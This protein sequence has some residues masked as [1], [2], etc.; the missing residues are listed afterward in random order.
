MHLGFNL[1]IALSLSIWTLAL[2]QQESDFSNGQKELE[3]LGSESRKDTNTNTIHN[4]RGGI[5]Q[6]WTGKRFQMKCHS[7]NHHSIHRQHQWHFLPC[8]PGY[9]RQSCKIL[10]SSLTTDTEWQVVQSQSLLDELVLESPMEKDN[11]LYKCS[12]IRHDGTLKV[13]RMFQLEVNDGTVHVPKIVEGPWNVSVVYYGRQQKI[14]LQCRVTSSV[15][16]KI[17]WFRR[18]DII[19][20]T[21]REDLII[22]KNAGWKMLPSNQIYLDDQLY[23]SKLS[24]DQLNLDDSGYYACLAINYKGW[25]MQEAHLKVYLPLNSTPLIAIGRNDQW[26]G[27]KFFSLFLIP[28][29]LALV[30]ASAWLCYL[31]HKPRNKQNV[32]FVS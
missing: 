3:A 2:I 23:L 16:P 4:A 30:P 8:G 21:G 12:T 10:R 14:S 31:Y 29:C 18:L 6:A 20:T 1:L 27:L 24:F 15:Q 11:G 22:Y 13:L 5:I 32:P 26:I 7:I 9:N 28:A 17:V 19:P 25:T